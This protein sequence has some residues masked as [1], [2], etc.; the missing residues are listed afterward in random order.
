M[1]SA[2]SPRISRSLLL[3]LF[4]GLAFALGT[5]GFELYFRTPMLETGDTALNAIRIDNA[6]HLRELYGNYSRFEF[7][8]PG[9]AFFYTYAAGE[10]LFADLLKIVP[11]ADNAHLLTCMLLQAFFFSWAIAILASHVRWRE[12]LTG[13]RPRG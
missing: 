4:L 12:S 11:G 9:P 6:K 5:A 13:R 8:H 1:T 3:C 7:S 10:V 2:S